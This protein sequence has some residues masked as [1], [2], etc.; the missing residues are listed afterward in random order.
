MLTQSI[1]K[2]SLVLAIFALI[3]SLLLASTY[4][5]TKDNI[6]AAERRAAQKILREIYPEESHDNDLLA[7]VL[8]VPEAYLATL[9]L[10]SATDIHVVRKGGDITGFII[11]A[12]APDGYSGDIRLLA[13]VNLDG[14]LAGI[15][16]LAHN[17]TPGLGD[18]VDTKKSDWIFE[19]DGKSLNNPQ[20]EQWKVKKDKGYFDQF[21]G[22]T[23]TPR[24][25][26]SRVYKTL[27][28]YREHRKELIK[29]AQ[30]RT[31][32]ETNE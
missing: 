12:T 14:S 29:S 4:L 10:K 6:N 11:P 23:I 7:D 22:A 28:F 26:V 5:G 2:N 3:T 15:R 16:V 13:G 18:K 9:G 20:E 17:E 21:T 27:I 1:G 25:V 24:A 30:K 31:A 8:P 32:G 19:F